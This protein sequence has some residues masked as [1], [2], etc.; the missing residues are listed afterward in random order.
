MDIDALAD[1]IITIEFSDD[2]AEFFDA[3]EF[4]DQN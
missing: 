4:L 3:N 1:D 2:D